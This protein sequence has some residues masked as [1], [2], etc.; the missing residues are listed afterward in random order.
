MSPHGSKDVVDADKYIKYSLIAPDLYGVQ[1]EYVIKTISGLVLRLFYSRSRDR[2]LDAALAFEHYG[3]FLNPAR[4]SLSFVRAKDSRLVTSDTGE[5]AVFLITGCV[6]D[7]YLRTPYSTGYDSDKRVHRLRL[8]LLSQEFQL[9][10]AYLG[11]AF[12]VHDLVGPV[13][14]P[15]FALSTRKEGASSGCKFFMENGGRFE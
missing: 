4:A 7:T 5:N 3:C 11:N 2:N 6:G 8:V 13:S 14:G 12:G 10:V 9:T 15:T 1:K